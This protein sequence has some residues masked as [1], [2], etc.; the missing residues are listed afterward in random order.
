[1]RQYD[2]VSH[3][4]LILSIINFALAAPVL[5]QEKHQTC[6]DVLYNPEDATTVLGKRGS[7]DVEL[8]DFLD[9][10]LTKPESS[11]GSAPSNPDHGA[12]NVIDGSPPNPATS[13]VSNHESM[14][15][16]GPSSSPALENW[17]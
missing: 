11:S 13:T 14:E 2:L 1:M 9:N 12:A 3:I 16:H 15:M 5:V 8:A 7:D 6:H 17:F 10:W 4:F